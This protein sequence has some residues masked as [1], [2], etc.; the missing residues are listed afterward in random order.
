[1]VPGEWEDQSAFIYDF[2]LLPA[3]RSKGL[4]SRAMQSL[5]AL[6]AGE[7]IRQIKLRVAAENAHAKK[8]MKPMATRSPAIT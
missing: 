4:G 1:M 5:E 7:G 2:Y 3:F 6:L 8:S